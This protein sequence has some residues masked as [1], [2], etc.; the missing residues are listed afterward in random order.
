MRDFNLFF[1]FKRN[2][3]S[4]KLGFG[5]DDIVLVIRGT[6]HTIFLIRRSFIGF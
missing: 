4:L 1:L 5:V 2:S 3:F 6:Y